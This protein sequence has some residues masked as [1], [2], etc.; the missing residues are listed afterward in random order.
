M[1]LRGGVLAGVLAELGEVWRPFFELLAK[2]GLRI[3]EAL[4][5]DWPDLELGA[6]PVLH[7]R[8]QFYRGT[9]KRLKSRNGRRDLPL[10]PGLARTLWV[11]R[12][13]HG[14]GPMFRTSA[15]TRYADRNVRRV[16]DAAAKRAGL[17]WVHFHTF[18]HTCASMLFDGGKNIK[19]VS[20]WLGH[21]DPAFT[22]RTYVHLMD[23]GLGDATFLDAA[24]GDAWAT[25]DPEKAATEH[26]AETRVRTAESGA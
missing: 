11:A 14:Q 25:E 4:G 21:A 3:S 17:E 12:P 9:L 6:R 13:A 19:Q 23:D 20:G 2:T 18:R 1:S 8:R 5:L 26:T 22:L 7:V 15:D 16:L 10:P 24:V